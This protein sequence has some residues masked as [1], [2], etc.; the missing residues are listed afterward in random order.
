MSFS[1]SS[2]FLIFLILGQL[3][4]ETNTGP[5]TPLTDAKEVQQVL[6]Q[7]CERLSKTGP[8]ADIDIAQLIEFQRESLNLLEKREEE[9]IAKHCE[10]QTKS[11]LEQALLLNWLN[12]PP[13]K[14]AQIEET[15]PK[16]DVPEPEL[17]LACD[18]ELA[19][20]EFAKE[21]SNGQ[22]NP[23][24]SQLKLFGDFR[25]P[26]LI[27]FWDAY[28]SPTQ[29]GPP[30][31]IIND[32]SLLE[33]Y[34]SLLLETQAI[35]IGFLK[36][37]TTSRGADIVSEDGQ[38]IGPFMDKGRVVRFVPLVKIPLV[39]RQAFIAAE[40]KNFYSHRGIEAQG[41]MR[42]FFK[43]LRDGSVEGGST[44]T[45]QLVKNLIL[46]NEVSLD[47]KAR[48]M[49]LARRLEDQLSKDQILE[50]YLNI[51]YLGR[52]ATGVASALERYFGKQARLDSVNLSQA[53]FFAGITHSPNRYNP[54]LTSPEKIKAR[55]SYVLDEMVTAKVIGKDEARTALDE[56]LAFQPL[57]FPK[58][59]YF[60][61]A[62][63]SEYLTTTPATL[64]A[65]EKI[66]SSQ[67]RDL[68]NFVD[69]SVQ[70][71][72]AD[73]EM[74][75]NKVYWR[76]P[77]R[78]IS[79]LWRKRQPF[80]DL[81]QEIAIWKDEVIKS[82]SLFTGVNWQVMVLLKN[83]GDYRVGYID[84]QGEAQITNLSFGDVGG[85]WYASIRPQLKVGDVIFAEKK[86]SGF[87]FRV[88]PT[89]QASILVMD[90]NTGEVKALNGGFDYSLAPYNRAIKALR[91][92]GSTVKPFTYLA[93]LE[94]GFQ[95][96]EPI[97]NAPL[98]FSKIPGCT[99][100][101]PQNYTR[102]TSDFVTFENGLIHSNNQ[103]TTQLLNEILRDP[104]DSL[105][106][107]YNTMVSFGLYD[108]KQDETICY[109]VTLGSKEVSLLRMAKAYAAI[110][111]GG[112][113]VSPTFLKKERTEFWAKPLTSY[114]RSSIAQ[115]S[116]ILSKVVRYGTG[117]ALNKHQGRVAGKTGTSSNYRDAWFTAYS[118][119][120]VV[121]AWMGYDEKRLRLPNGSLVALSM[122]SE[123]TGGRL[124]APMV[125]DIFDFLFSISDTRV[126]SIDPGT[127][128]NFEPQQ[129]VFDQIWSE[130][131]TQL[132][133]PD[134]ADLPLFQRSKFS[135]M[136]RNSDSATTKENDFFID[137][138][139]PTMDSSRAEITVRTLPSAP[140]FDDFGSEDPL[141]MSSEMQ[142]VLREDSWQRMKLKIDNLLETTN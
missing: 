40:D 128:L 47:R 4:Q 78:N 84:D 46:G 36:N 30:P 49:L 20:E 79:Y 71:Y 81:E 6:R 67:N 139:R 123:S 101:S 16:R 97:R 116:E 28:C 103:V 83:Q 125:S 21:F 130:Q 89:L 10:E 140:I 51:V 137:D 22:E 42:G 69:Q 80:P 114:R 75:N 38:L 124:V 43:Y 96:F 115:L 59:S 53:S 26:D 133:A 112:W 32:E 86:E 3:S 87:Y 61:E 11:T 141:Q 14:I 107:V 132:G 113:L 45:Q 104:Q 55:Q 24:E 109:P 72:L 60:Q 119:Y 2:V 29:N 31:K 82:Q 102:T 90:V 118:N 105:R 8:L 108:Y 12:P 62:A 85:S 54:S 99:P 68:Q 37:Y 33:T 15:L 134:W 93:A 64:K 129:Y 44:I 74:Q 76:G 39:V 5:L 66:V 19:R 98:F 13:K 1:A 17:D 88:Q 34:N 73:Y 77:L 50:A 58:T 52:G 117:F 122:G 35:D 111:N 94:Q 9:F 91:Q 138:P 48:E 110:A 136:F 92:P 127:P 100:W 121:V 23:L 7:S 25:I 120:H 65:P 57:E 142:D 18:K 63:S 56:T 106:L 41:I 27:E 135:D 126:I 131:I 95:P 70:K